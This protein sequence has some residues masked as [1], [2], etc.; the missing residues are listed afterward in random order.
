MAPGLRLTRH[1][2]KAKPAGRLGGNFP[3]SGEGGPA[4]PAGARK[5]FN[6]ERTGSHQTGGF[7]LS[8]DRPDHNAK[9]VLGS[10]GTV[11]LIGYV[12]LA[13]PFGQDH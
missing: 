7:H 13:H 12:A 2:L 10:N 6:I 3:G 8:I 9:A 1:Q 11:E 5:G 4:G